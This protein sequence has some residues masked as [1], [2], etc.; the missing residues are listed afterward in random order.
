MELGG[1][2][3]GEAT[4]AGHPD[5]A[6]DRNSQWK[7]GVVRSATGRETCEELVFR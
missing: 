1:E 7:I 2:E 5:R 4:S 3:V 6:V